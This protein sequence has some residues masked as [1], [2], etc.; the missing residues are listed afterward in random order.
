VRAIS[1][2][3][4][5]AV[6]F[7]WGTVFFSPFFGRP[8]EA[9]TFS[10]LYESVAEQKRDDNDTR[11][12]YTS[13][14]SKPTIAST[15]SWW[16]EAWT[17]DFN[18]WRPLTMQAFWLEKQAFGEEHPLTWMRVTL[19]LHFF[20]TALFA[21]LVLRIAK[22]WDVV[23]LSVLL[24]TAPR[25]VFLPL[26]LYETPAVDVIYHW[27]DQPDLFVNILV[28]GA[29]LA[30]LDRRW[31]IS[32][33]CSALAVCFKESGWL[34]FPMVATAVAFN[35]GWRQIPKW[36]Y[37]AIV[38]IAIVL[39]TFRWSAGRDVFFGRSNVHNAHPI[40]RYWNIAMEGLFTGAVWKLGQA[41]LAAGLLVL[42]IIRSRPVVAAVAFALLVPLSVAI[43]ALQM[44]AT[45]DAAGAAFF[46]YESFDVLLLLIWGG[47]D[48]LGVSK[49]I[50]TAPRA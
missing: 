13:L 34:S 37:G 20:A 44:N 41:T 23:A 18:Y 48:I 12:I 6:M 30:A 11:M 5:V 25:P 40:W 38:A 8:G 42:A 17:P 15:L 7:F 31:I 26:K 29:M 4:I 2:A 14:E 3:M 1:A 21:L 39:L 19:A 9:Y 10:N 47:L 22:R 27:K 43:F 33:I 45:Y 46:V 16:H 36:V 35:G 32:L 24:F 28:V 50:A 49:P